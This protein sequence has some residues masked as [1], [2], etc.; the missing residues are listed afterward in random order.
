MQ[1]NY[2]FIRIFKYLYTTT[3]SQGI[4][5]SHSNGNINKKS[6]FPLSQQ[7]PQKQNH[8]I[9]KNHYQSTNSITKHRCNQNYSTIK[10]TINKQYKN[11]KEIN[12]IKNKLQQQTNYTN[13]RDVKKRRKQQYKKLTP[14]QQYK[15][16]NQLLLQLD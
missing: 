8:K 15:K 7:K 11:S 1:W 13:K 4:T 2:L 16:A 5:D 14:M 6:N 9:H 12:N 3:Q 10:S